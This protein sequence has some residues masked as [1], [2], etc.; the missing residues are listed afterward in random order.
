M[1]LY[2]NEHVKTSNVLKFLVT[3]LVP[4]LGLYLYVRE[5]YPLDEEAPAP[6]SAYW[7]FFYFLVFV[8]TLLFWVPGIVMAFV[9]AFFNALSQTSP[10]K[11]M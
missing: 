7:I 6:C 2:G 8:L 11:S 9:L 5:Y 4:P 10:A 3:I 1:V